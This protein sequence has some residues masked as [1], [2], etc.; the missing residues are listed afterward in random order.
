MFKATI[1]GNLGRIADLRQTANGNTVCSFSVAASVRKG[2]EEQTVWVRA[3]IWGVVGE[4]LAPYLIKGQKVAIA[5]DITTSEWVTKDGETRF[6]IDCKVDSIELIG[7][8]VDAPPSGKNPDDTAASQSNE[9]AD[10][11]PDEDVPF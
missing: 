5:G 7:K 2:K 4:H 11:V 9:P 3:T 8:P 6:N 10:F 1:T